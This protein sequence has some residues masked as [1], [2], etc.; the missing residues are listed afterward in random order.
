M[1]H[2]GKNVQ[3]SPLIYFFIESRI[4]DKFPR[5]Q[6]YHVWLCCKFNIFL[7]FMEQSDESKHFCPLSLFLTTGRLVIENT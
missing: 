7:T 2:A 1:A 4:T 3:F 6:F 5:T